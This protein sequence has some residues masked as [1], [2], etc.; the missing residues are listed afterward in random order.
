[1]TNTTTID[2]N[3]LATG[4]VVNGQYTS[5]GVTISSL[6]KTG[7]IDTHNPPMIFNTAHPTGGDTD[8]KTNNLGK[9]LIL[10]EDRDSN[11]PD[12]NASGGI[13]RFDF[14]GTADVK[15]LTVLDVEEGAWIKL[16]DKDGHLLKQVDVHTANNGQKNVWLDTPGVAYMD[17]KLGGSG[18]V[19]NLAFTPAPA[20]DGIITGD[21]S[22]ER[23]TADDFVDEDGE[24]VDGGDALLPGEGPDDDIIKAFGGNDTVHAGAG[25]DEVFGGTG[26]DVLSG[27]KGDDFIDGEEG[28]DTIFG[29][30]G[31]DTILGGDG[32]DRIEGRNDAD[33]IDGGAGDD[34]IVGYDAKSVSSGDTR[35]EEDDKS[36]DTLAGGDGDDTV[37]GGGG[38][39]VLSGDAGNDLLKGGADDDALSGGDG[40]DTLIGGSGDDTADGG[41]KMDEIWM[42]SGDDVASGGDGNDWMHGQD[43]ADTLHGDAGDDMVFGEDGD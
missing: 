5:Q 13:F 11:D 43:G 23:I 28:N 36:D 22:S 16:Y 1:M 4:T 21:N 17:V 9:V 34:L 12:D 40:M 24:V 10:S 39:D 6:T 8:L 33:S 38:N 25:D 7:S 37:L 15:S 32:H 27:D 26:N 19:D 3:N 18:A 20:P 14:D 31:D 30:D 2:F 29:G 35:V 41:A 42:G